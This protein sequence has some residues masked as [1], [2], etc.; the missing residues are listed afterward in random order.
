VRPIDILKV[1]SAMP[2]RSAATLIAMPSA[3]K[4]NACCVLL[5]AIFS[6]K[7]IPVVLSK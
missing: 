7:T 4:R 6:L 2:A 1:L 5:N 3:T